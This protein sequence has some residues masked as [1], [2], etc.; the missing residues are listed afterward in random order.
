MRERGRS[1]YFQAITH[2]FLSRRGVPF[3]L[4]STDIEL[5]GTWEK[6][7]IPLQV[8]LEGIE[9]TFE[10][11]RS[12]PGR[13]RRIH[14]LA[15]CKLHVLKAFEQYRERKVGTRKRKE[16]R[17]EKRKRIKNEVRNFL[18]DFPPDLGYLRDVYSKAQKILSRRKVEEEELERLEEEIEEL[19]LSRCPRLEKEKVKVEISQEYP[20]AAEEEFRTLLKIKLVKLLREKYKIPYISFFYY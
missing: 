13:R 3:F 5:I 19:L 16:E 4:S 6:M 1:Q 2:H 7:G 14:S 8:V 10:S 15:F 12:K 9:R 17:D 18:M 11:E 20:S